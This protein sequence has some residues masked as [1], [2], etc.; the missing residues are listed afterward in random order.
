[1]YK[2]KYCCEEFNRSTDLAN[3]VKKIHINRPVYGRTN[4]PICHKLISLA[5]NTYQKHIKYCQNKRRPY[6]CEQCGKLV[7][8]DYYFGSGRFCSKVCAN[9]KS[10]DQTYR[11]KIS[12][13]LKIYYKTHPE[14]LKNTLGKKWGITNTKPTTYMRN[15]KLVISRS[16][17]SRDK[18]VNHPNFCQYCGEPL[19]Y[20][21]KYRITCG[22][23]ECKYKKCG[24]LRPG[25]TKHK[26]KTG[27]YSGIWCDST[28]ELVF[29]VFC[30]DHN[31]PFRR[32]ADG[33][34]YFYEGKYHLFYPDF[35]VN[36]RFYVEI[37]GI[38][39][40]INVAK[41]TSVPYKIR[42]LYREDLKRCFDYVREN[43]G[44]S[45]SK[46]D[47]LYDKVDFK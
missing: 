42:F 24:G 1:M 3:H 7:T 45:I 28:Y 33:F 20:E 31:I 32:N 22:R 15:G 5:P 35:I 38:K 2:C 19:S 4:C 36:D 34:T 26:G 47:T 8:S 46:L 39:D 10:F 13:S 18:Y 43:Y 37:K 23:K 16:P 44:V 12:D 40:S 9:K 21:R 6:K 17:I 14:H 25:T 41:E 30:L 27:Y 11:K 29:V